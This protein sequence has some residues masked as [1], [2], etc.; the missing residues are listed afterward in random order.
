VRKLRFTRRARDDLLDIWAYIAA[1]N[2]A[3]ADRFY[4]RIDEKFG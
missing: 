2:P 3:A 4:D 1:N